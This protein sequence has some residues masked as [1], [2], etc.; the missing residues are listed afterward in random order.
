M[1]TECRTCVNVHNRL[2]RRPATNVSSHARVSQ[3]YP[4]KRR[5]SCPSTHIAGH[6]CSEGRRRGVMNCGCAVGRD[7]RCA[8]GTMR[9][10]GGGGGGG[11]GGPVAGGITT[12]VMR[13]QR[14]LHRTPVQP[15]SMSSQPTLPQGSV[16]ATHELGQL[17]PP[18]L[19]LSSTSLS[20]AASTAAL[21]C[22]RL[23]D[24][25]RARHTNAFSSCRLR[26]SQPC[27]HATAA[28]TRSTNATPAAQ[29]QY[30]LLEVSPG[31]AAGFG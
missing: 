31:R 4:Q 8:P 15:V 7:T 25:E 21:H 6:S 29:R 20:L 10:H 3:V 27:H 11:G 2:K 13:P 23:C 14:A 28:T 9:E 1:P 26:I 5:Q 18:D 22:A 24:S 19:V 12:C 30:R 16:L 17:L